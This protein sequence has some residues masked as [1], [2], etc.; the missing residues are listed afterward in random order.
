MSI[1]YKP[2][3]AYCLLQPLELVHTSQ[4][5]LPPGYT[6]DPEALQPFKVI[7]VGPGIVQDGAL[8]PVCVSVGEIVSVSANQMQMYKDPILGVLVLVMDV[9]I[10][11]VI[12]GLNLA[13]Y[14][15]RTEFPSPDPAGMP[16]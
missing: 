2:T 13:K 12:D 1:T 14:T 10:N 6:V 16:S 7:A 8:V 5:K 11:C 4:L 3:H 9:A 15:H